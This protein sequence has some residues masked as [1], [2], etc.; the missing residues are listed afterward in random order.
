MKHLM[1]LPVYNQIE[2]FP[3]VLRE[4]KAEKLPCDILLVNNGSRDG[5]EKLIH[6]SGFEFVDLEKNMGVGYAFMVAIRFALEK[7]YDTVGSMAGNGKMLASEMHRL[8]EPLESGIADYVTGSRFLP[9]GAYPNLPAFRRRAIPMVNVFV[10]MLTG[11]YLTDVTCGYRL[12]KTDIIRAARFDWEQ[13]GLYTYGLEYYLYAEVVMSGKYR[14]LEVPVTMRYP[15]KGR[16]Y[17]KIPPFSGWWQMLRP[18][19]KARFQRG[20]FN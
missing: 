3:L 6:D 8:V 16:R 11:R 1:F 12:F 9:G 20:G 17:S 13:P 5:T 4:L 10:W 15:P 2:E 14:F 7:G 19:L 18:W